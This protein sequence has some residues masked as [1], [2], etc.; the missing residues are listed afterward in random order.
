MG[1][2]VVKCDRCKNDFVMGQLKQ[3]PSVN[4]VERVCFSCPHCQTDYTAYYTN[5]KI[6]DRQTE[7]NELN[8]KMHN[9]QSDKTKERYIKQIEL[10][11]QQNK[12]EMESLRKE[13]EG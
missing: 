12:K 7:I 10:L 13:I 11:T 3:A 2:T 9:A 1:E 6:R 5:Q 4:E 8:K